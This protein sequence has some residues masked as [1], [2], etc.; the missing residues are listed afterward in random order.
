[1]RRSLVWG[2][3]GAV[4]LKSTNWNSLVNT[5]A[6]FSTG[7]FVAD[8]TT[9]HINSFQLKGQINFGTSRYCAGVCNDIHKL[10]DDVAKKHRIVN[11]IKEIGGPRYFGQFLHK[12]ICRTF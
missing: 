12:M 5:E 10:L 8:W 6:T 1:M 2:E 11:S 3:G 7:S 4:N 9:I